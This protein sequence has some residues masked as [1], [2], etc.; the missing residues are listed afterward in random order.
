MWITFEKFKKSVDKL[1]KL[2]YSIQVATHKN[3]RSKWS[4]KIEQQREVL[5]KEN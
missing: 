2:C 4:L 3:V 5:V 1:K